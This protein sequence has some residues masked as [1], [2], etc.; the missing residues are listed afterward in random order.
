V[1]A[2]TTSAGVDG[3]RPFRQLRARRFEAPGLAQVALHALIDRGV[4][5]EGED[6]RCGP[7]DRHRDRRARCAQIEARVE[8][9]RVVDAADRD[10]RVTDLAVHVGS[11]VGVATV[12]RDAVECGGEPRGALSAAQQVEAAIGAF[13]RS[14]AG[15]HARGLLALAPE[16]EDT[17]RKWKA[18]GQVLAPEVAHQLAPVV[19]VRQR[20]LRE[21][22]AGEGRHVVVD[23]DLP[24]AH[25]VGLRR[26]GVARPNLGPGLERL[27]ICV[28]QRG[29]R[30]SA[31]FGERRRQRGVRRVRRRGSVGR[32]ALAPRPLQDTRGTRKRL[33]LGGALGCDLRVRVPAA[34]PLGDLGEIAAS[35]GR[36]QRRRRC[37]GA[38]EN[39]RAAVRGEVGAQSSVEAVHA[40]IVPAP[41][42]GGIHRDLTIGKRQLAAI[43]APLPA[44]VAQGIFSAL[45]IELVEHDEVGHVEH[46]DLLELRGGS[47]LRCHDVHGAVDQID[48]LGVAL[49]DTGRLDQDQIEVRRLQDAHRIHDRARER[50]VG[51]P[52]RE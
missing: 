11:L 28:R 30:R 39:R 9:H 25:G 16:R 24:P 2:S 49:A 52:G 20:H 4:Q 15:E 47:V 6:D 51:A 42:H 26:G 50:K 48:D 33:R 19:A 35:R 36:N 37:R 45:A 34:H 29:A 46:V 8:L 43:A 40:G 22:R 18:A 21:P 38:H 17:R 5:E 23:A 41:R 1:S 14:L 32:Q 10:A 3:K 12:E 7:V 31:A 27:A 44:H 13:G